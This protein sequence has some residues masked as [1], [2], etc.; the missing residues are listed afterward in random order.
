MTETETPMAEDEPQGHGEVSDWEEGGAL[1]D[2]D[3]GDQLVVEVDLAKIS[4]VALA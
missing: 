1:L 4:V 3:S 2:A